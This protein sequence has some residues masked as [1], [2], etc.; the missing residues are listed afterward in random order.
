[1]TPTAPLMLGPTTKGFWLPDPVSA[2]EFVAA[3][4]DLTDGSFVPPLLTLRES[5][6]A[7]NLSEMAHYARRHGVELAPHGKT[8][9][10]A[11]LFDRQREAGAWGISVATPA[12]ALTAHSVGVDRIIIANEVLEVAALEWIGGCGDADILFWIDS[13][14]GLDQV[15]QVADGDRTFQV[16][17]EVG[18]DGGRTGV[19]DLDH[20]R[21]LAHRAAAI[22]GVHVRGVGGYEGALTDLASVRAF[23]HTMVDMARALVA[24]ATVATPVILTAGG[25][26][27]FDLV[28]DVCG[29]ADI[30]AEA[31]TVLRS[32]AY[33]THDHGIY[34][35]R[36]PFRR[37]P[38]WLEP[39]IRVWARVLSCPEPGLV[40]LG[41]G[42]RDLPVDEGFP[43]PL[44]RHRS[45]EVVA[46][47][48][49]QITRT[50][51]QHAYL[52]PVGADPTPLQP[53]DLLELGI[54]HPCTAMDKYR[55][56]PVVDDQLRVVDVI[57]TSF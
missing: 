24:D 17:V 2:R 50:N 20:G 3:G 12:Q 26:A 23:L 5:A 40:I 49:W 38:G 39:A 34:S 37:M 25:S 9:M 53:G 16:I 27:Y 44:Q 11:Q 33:L 55:V 19:R 21:E 28:A 54:S 31:I 48:G 14:A 35:E 30:G 29:R 7:H 42:K 46:V 18:H 22:A 45:P 36:T 1:M 47:A 15:E 41:A 4:H 57:A 32:G 52:E 56:V 6:L 13:A 51:D 8:T 10:S 43:V